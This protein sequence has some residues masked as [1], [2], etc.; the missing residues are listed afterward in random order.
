MFSIGQISKK[1]SLSRSTIIYYDSIGVLSPSG[2]TEANYRLYSDLDVQKMEKIVQYRSAGLSLKSISNILNN[3]NCKLYSTLENRLFEIN[4][5][6]QSLRSQQKLILQLLKSK[7]SLKHSRIVSKED[8]IS[9]LKA[10]GLD[11][12]GMKKWNIEFEKMAP[13]AHQDFLE[14]L[15]IESNEIIVIRDWSKNAANKI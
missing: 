1:F 14:S 13:E 5:E 15:G 3:D 7:K 10:T 4:L 2:R 8:W 9:L 12:E 11:D 6:I